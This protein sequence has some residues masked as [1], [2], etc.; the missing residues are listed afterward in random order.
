MHPL[1]QNA[2]ITMVFLE[3]GYST[4]RVAMQTKTPRKKYGEGGGEFRTSKKQS[5]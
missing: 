3:T 5:E 1:T 4:P 2:F